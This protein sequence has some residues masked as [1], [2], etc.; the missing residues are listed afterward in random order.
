MNELGD[1]S[2]VLT[3]LTRTSCTGWPKK[4]P[5]SRIIKSY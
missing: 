2:I 5:L 1:R 3:R 4:V